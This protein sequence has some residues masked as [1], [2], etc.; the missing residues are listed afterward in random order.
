MNSKKGNRKTYQPKSKEIK[1]EWHLI[2]AKGKVLGRLASEIAKLLMG[3]H[4]VKYASHLDMG[5]IVV[6][7]NA[8]EVRLTGRKRE[9]KV[10]RRHSGYPGGFKEISFKKML[11]DHPEKII[12]K[13]VF[14]MLP[15][16]RLK[17]K[18]MNRLKVFAGK[19][20]P[21]KK[22]VGKGEK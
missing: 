6:V 3:K 21:Y 17:S 8:K 11:E 5:D 14:G 15:G 18:R 1:R 16:N 20:H 7:T 2:D 12:Q 22:M 4:K 13:A 19:D 10:Y 9:Q